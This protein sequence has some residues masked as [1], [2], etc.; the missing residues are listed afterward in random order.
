MTFRAVT[1]SVLERFRLRAALALLNLIRPIVI[2]LGSQDQKR[3]FAAEWETHDQEMGEK[4]R[5]V[6]R[7]A[8][9]P[10]PPFQ[11]F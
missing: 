5:S 3:E 2:K 1:R 11:H 9:D 8:G 7:Q 10:V 6:H 4:W